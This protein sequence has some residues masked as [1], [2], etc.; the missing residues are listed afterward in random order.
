MFS[1]FEISISCFFPG[2][3]LIPAAVL[4]IIAGGFIMNKLKLGVIGIVR[5]LLLMKFY[6]NIGHGNTIHNGMFFNRP[7]W[8][9]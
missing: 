4:G 6:S 7:C 8:H 2:L 3:V 1:F 9:N 5:F